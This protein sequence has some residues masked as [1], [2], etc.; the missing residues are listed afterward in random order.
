VSGVESRL[1]NDY[2][3]S[4]RS[5]IRNLAEFASA[6]EHRLVYF[7]KRAQMTSLRKSNSG[8]LFLYILTSILLSGIVLGENAVIF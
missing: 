7:E 4:S 6:T 5:H 8:V 2:F 1:E 3:T